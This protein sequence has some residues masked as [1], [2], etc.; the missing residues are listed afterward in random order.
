MFDLVLNNFTTDKS[1]GKKFFEK[2]IQEAISKLGL[3]KGNLELSIN[4]VGEGRIKALNKK[5]LGKNRKTDV[6]SFP[7]TG[8][9]DVKLP[10]KSSIIALGDI[11]ICLP[12]A[13][14]QALEKGESLD[15]RLALLVIHGL[16]HLLGYE[17]EKSSEK[18][19][20]M[21]QLQE[22]IL[23]DVF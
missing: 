17:H 23:K 9:R 16:L 4:L 12:V 19:K 3:E 22:E 5:Y 6:L 1:H 18:A 14:K 11:F 13:K 8:R 10:Q 20:E 7:L 2:I 21:Y 15:Q